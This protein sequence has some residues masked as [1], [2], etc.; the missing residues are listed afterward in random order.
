MNKII[1]IIQARMGSTRLPGKVLMNL[2]G[3][4]MLSHI[5]H[6]VLRARTPQ[7]IVIT[8]SRRSIDDEIVGL[9]LVNKWPCFRGSEH[10]VLD[11]Y[12]RTA[13]HFRADTIIRI[14]SDCP[15]IDPSIIDRVVHDLLQRPD[16]DYAS[17]A[18]G[19]RTFPQGLEVEGIKF[20]SLEHA[21]REDSNLAWRE[22]VTP[23]IYRH[24]EKFKLYPVVNNADWSAI[25]WTVDTQEDFNLVRN[26]Y[27]YFGD[28]DFS[29]RD[30]LSLLQKRPKWGRINQHVV[31]KSVP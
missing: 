19:A 20:R 31:Q 5:I 9:C 22:H 15:L 4:P 28:Q 24:P 21:W 25:R 14:T 1:A 2:N 12:Y 7:E 18:L 23:Y 3:R 13:S 10:D 17:N 26:I 11:R 27:E 16:V 8:T 6:R 30:A 29:W